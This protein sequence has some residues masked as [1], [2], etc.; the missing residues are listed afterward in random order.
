MSKEKRYKIQNRWLVDTKNNNKEL[1]AIDS[2]IDESVID[3]LNNQDQQIADLQHRLEVAAK[4]LFKYRSYKTTDERIRDLENLYSD[5]KKE[6]QQL[7]QS[8]KQLAIE[9]LKGLRDK[10]CDIGYDEDYNT[11]YFEVMKEIDDQIKSLKGEE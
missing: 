8:Q 6:N 1:Y 4:E 5:Y 11:D 9:E 3:L 10:I 2:Y 7:K